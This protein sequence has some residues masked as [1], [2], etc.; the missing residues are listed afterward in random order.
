MDIKKYSDF[1]HDGG[2]INI[3]Q[4]NN[5]IEIS[6]ESNQIWPEWNKDKIPLS[7]YKTI[8]GK[9]HLEGVTNITEDHI[10]QKLIYMNYDSGEILDFDINDNKIKLLVI[11]LNY[12][13]KPKLDKTE[14]IEIEAKKIFWENIPDLFNPFD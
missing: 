12:P 3:M 13:P 1:F 4:K 5:S 7:S 14:L 6:M 9:L 8:K 11:W 2:I 10:N